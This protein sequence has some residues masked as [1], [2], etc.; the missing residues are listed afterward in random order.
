MKPVDDFPSLGMN[1][2]RFELLFFGALTLLVGD[3]KSIQSVEFSPVISAK[4]S[5]LED[6]KEEMWRGNPL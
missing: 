1:D 4:G 2:Q 5:A 3:R 6:T